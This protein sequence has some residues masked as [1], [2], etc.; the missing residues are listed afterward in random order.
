MQDKIVIDGVT[1]VREEP[2][3]IKRNDVLEYA[4]SLLPE[5]KYDS[6][7]YNIEPRIFGKFL[8][9]RFP[10]CNTDWTFQVFDMVKKIIEKYPQIY[11]D[12]FESFKRSSGGDHYMA[13]SLERIK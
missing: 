12:H 1:Y 7:S 4:E 11:P 9:L 10:S 8:L 6:V 5:T 13:L 2:K 3:P